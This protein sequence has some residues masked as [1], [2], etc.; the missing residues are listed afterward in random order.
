[1]IC[2]WFKHGGI[3]KTNRGPAG[4]VTFKGQKVE[5]QIALEESLSEALNKKSYQYLKYLD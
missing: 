2:L 1:M 3:I 4:G 5:I